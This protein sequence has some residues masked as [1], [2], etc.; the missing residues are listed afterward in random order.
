[1]VRD[2]WIDLRA[3]SWVTGRG[4][5]L[6]P[7]YMLHWRP[8]VHV[9]AITPD[10]RVVMVRQF[11]PG[12]EAAMLELPGGVVDEDGEGSVRAAAER[13]LLEETGFAAE[14]FSEYAAPFNDP[15]H[16]TNRVH[17]FFALSARRVAEQALDVAEDIEVVLVPV[18]EVIAGLP[19]GLVAH[20]S[21]I[22]TLYLG[23]LAAGRIVVTPTSQK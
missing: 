7:W 1:M 17:L 6:D 4:A 13:E 21:H 10:E 15:A 18:A 5:A 3:E 12:A 20:A 22:G 11:R 16:A 8:W 9:V 14:G 23:L 19:Q 2:Q